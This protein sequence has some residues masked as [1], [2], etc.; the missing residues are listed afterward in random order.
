[1][2]YFPQIARQVILYIFNYTWYYQVYQYIFL[3]KA[4]ID[5]GL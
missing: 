1:M 2:K 5:F 3:S 4:R